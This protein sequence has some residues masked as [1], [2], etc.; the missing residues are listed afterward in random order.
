MVRSK[1]GRYQIRGKL[2][3]GGM[4]TVYRAFDPNFDRE[5][6]VKVLPTQFLHDSTFQARFKREAKIIASLE[7]PAIVPVY[8]FGEENGQPFIVMRLMNGG[9]LADR[10]GQKPLSIAETARIIEWLAPALDEAH[11]RSIIHRDLKPENILFDKRHAPYIADFGIAKYSHASQSFTTQGGL[12]GTPAYMSPEQWRGE[13]LDGRSDLYTLGVILFEMLTGTCPFQAN[14][15]A[16]TMYK[17][18]LE[19]IPNIRQLRRDLPPDCQTVIKQAMAKDREV[20]Y[21]CVM[22]LASDLKALAP[23]EKTTR[24]Q[25]PASILTAKEPVRQAANQKVRAPRK[26]RLSTTFMNKIQAYRRKS[27]PIP[28]T[29]NLAVPNLNLGIGAKRQTEKDGMTMVYVPAGSFLRGSADWD[30]E[31]YEEEKPQREL[32]LDAFWIDQ[33]PVTN[34]MFLRFVNET[35]YRTQAEKEGGSYVFTQSSDG[36]WD[37]VDGANW[38]HPLGPESNLTDLQAH[39]VVHVNWNDAQAYCQWAGRR[40][41]TEAEWEKA[42][43]SSDGRLYPWGNQKVAGNLLNFADRNLDAPGS[44]DNIDDGYEYTSPVGSYPAGASLYGALDMAGNVWE[45]VADYFDA[46]YYKYAPAH[47]PPGPQSGEDRVLRGGS[48]YYVARHVRAANRYWFG[49]TDRVN[50]VGFRCACS[51]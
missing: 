8:D 33:T 4:G 9:S 46:D 6:A 51:P 1:I 15:P 17:H 47:N 13:V 39:P 44:D 18:L 23:T 42:A 31:A 49:P 37:E 11:K 12:I 41:P 21:T 43:R 10:L 3:R 16:A 35:A 48:W 26:N 24:A 36:Y 19:P 29:K 28:E 5:V 38:R 20:R 27:Q 25:K 14:T 7:H 32:Y 34:G 2:G 30:V 22:A 40:L 45:W 50:N